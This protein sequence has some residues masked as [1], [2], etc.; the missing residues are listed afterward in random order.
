MCPPLLLYSYCAHQY[1]KAPKKPNPLLA[2]ILPPGS[3]P[4]SKYK[5][6]KLLMQQQAEAA[7]REASGKRGRDGTGPGTASAASVSLVELHVPRA[8]RPKVIIPEG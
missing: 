5:L 1:S 8:K 2:V 3:P 7:L 4:L 6:N